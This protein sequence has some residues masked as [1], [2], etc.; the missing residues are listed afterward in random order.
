MKSNTVSRHQNIPNPAS[1][2]AFTLVELLV[3]IAIL[4]LVAAMSLP[5]LCKTNIKSQGFQC[6]SNLKTL[7][8]AWTSWSLDNGE[9]L[10]SC[11]DW[12]GASDMSDP[13]TIDFIDLNKKLLT[14]PLNLYLQGNTK[15]YKCPSDIRVSTNPLYKGTPV[16]R[17]L[18]MNIWIGQG[19][20]GYITFKKASDLSRPGPS[21]TFIIAD[22]SPRTINDGVLLIQMDTYDP[23]NLPGKAWVD[24][25]A[26]YH[27]NAGTLSFADG[28]V[29]IHRWT[30]A[31]TLTATLAAASPNNLDIDW[32]QS[33]SS[34]KITN[35]TR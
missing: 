13:S 4:A 9:Q 35:P 19:D 22:E 28:H 2:R 12:Y 29:E 31:R 34:A 21:N 7:T 27:S 32:L 6:M 23:N 25:P 14:S 11:R 8:A 10:M 20:V 33:K 18:S 16:A 5:A 15:F 30:D 24:V 17:S 3:V 1:Q 26:A